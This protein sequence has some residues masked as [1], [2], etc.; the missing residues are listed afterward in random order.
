MSASEADFQICSMLKN[1]LTNGV[2]IETRNSKVKRLTNLVATFNTTPLISI[3]KTAWK[4]ALLEMEWFLS[5]SS[6]INDLD[7][8]VHSWWKPWTNAEGEIPNSYSKQFR[9]YN[10]G[11]V[12]DF[13]HVNPG[14]DQIKILIDGL[15]KSPYSRRNVIT[16]WQTEDMISPITSIT[17]CHGTVIQA[18]VSP[19]DKLS[20]TMYQR[21]ADMIL[22]LPHNW[23]QYWAFLLYLAKQT[24][25]VPESFT[26]IGGDC[27]IYENAFDVAKEMYTK[28]NTIISHED[29]AP[30]LVYSGVKGDA[31]KAS[32]F[33]LSSEYKPLILTSPTMVV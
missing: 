5:G 13:F 24:D 25:K 10:H 11:Y 32:D 16:T 4:S 30:E 9:K 1:I 12:C 33:T 3:R 26:W 23:I 27:H 19:G 6:N 29:K 22:G 2:E 31:F 15:N 17:N 20:L 8:K 7:P 18:F 21:S 14:I 28:L